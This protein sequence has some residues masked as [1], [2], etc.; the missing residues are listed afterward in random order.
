MRPLFLLIF[1]AL[2]GWIGTAATPPPGAREAD[3]KEVVA[4]TIEV[5]DRKLSVTENFRIARHEVTQELYFAVTGK[6]PA[7]HQDERTPGLPVENV[8]WQDAID[9]CRLL[10][11]KFPLP[12]NQSYTLPTRDQWEFAARGGRASRGFRYA[13]GDVINE[14]AWQYMNSIMSTHPAGQL[15]ANELGLY[16]FSGNVWEWC[17]DA[18]RAGKRVYR[19]GSFFNYETACDPGMT[20][21]AGDET[22]NEQIGFRL[23]IVSGSRSAL[24]QSETDS[25]TPSGK[26]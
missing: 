24:N 26:N 19:G 10:N 8:S 7:F 2:P 22:R 15:K 5:G 23:A 17:L 25:G 9:F 21:T 1:A 3:F 16:D 13:G 6:N 18:D 14:V 4:G 11:E 12:G 20:A